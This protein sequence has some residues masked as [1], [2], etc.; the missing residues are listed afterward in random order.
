MLSNH[1]SFIYHRD[2]VRPL[3]SPHLE[4]VKDGLYRP[5]SAERPPFSPDVSSLRHSAS[6]RRLKHFAST[7]SPTL[8]PSHLLTA[9]MSFPLAMTSRSQNV[10]LNLPKRSKLLH[11]YVERS[12]MDGFIDNVVNL[13]NMP[14]LVAVSNQSGPLDDVEELASQGGTSKVKKVPVSQ[15]RLLCLC[16]IYCPNACFLQLISVTLS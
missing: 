4:V 3:M 8:P 7:T 11:N 15:P 14:N 1:L 16:E 10:E 5:S 12:G 9:S 13:S 2:L 6:D